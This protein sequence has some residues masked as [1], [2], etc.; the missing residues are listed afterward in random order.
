[1]YRKIAFSACV[2]LGLSA[3]AFAET[4]V[5]PVKVASPSLLKGEYGATG[6]DVCLVSSGGFDSSNQPIGGSNV[7][8][9]YLPTE[10][11]LN[12]DGKGNGTF[13]GTA[14]VVI[15]PPVTGFSPSASTDD[16]SLSYTYTVYTNGSFVLQM[17][18]NSFSGT[19]LNGP[20]QNLNFTIDQ[21]PAFTG[22]IGSSDTINITTTFNQPTVVETVTFPAISLVTPRICYRQRV[23]IA[24][25]ANTGFPP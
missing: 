11:I 21:E 7:Y 17:V 4:E 2:L 10:G 25:K 8:A 14:G 15:P 1:M 5:T 9:E 20:L 13:T 3:H 22:L 6:I 16:F 24:L 18:P 12:F 23:M 19:A